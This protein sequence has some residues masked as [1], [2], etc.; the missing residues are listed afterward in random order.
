M[1]K[2][3]KQ[4]FVSGLNNE[5]SVFKTMADWRDAYDWADL[6]GCRKNLVRYITYG[7]Y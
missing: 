4:Y 7:G 2:Y 1:F 3:S 6:G 5:C